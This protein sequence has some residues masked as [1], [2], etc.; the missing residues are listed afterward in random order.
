M[1]SVIRKLHA[2]QILDSRGNPTVEVEC[3]LSGGAHARAAVPSGAS[4]GSREAMEL[5]DGDPNSYRG[6]GVARAVA[7]VNGILASELEGMNASAQSE[8]DRRM[9]ELDGTENKS[10]LGAN[11]IL[12]VSLV[13]ARAAATASGV[14]LFRHLG[15]SDASRLPVPHMNILNGGVHAHWQG[16]DFQEFMIAPHGAPNF[17]EALRW[18]SEIYHA[19]LAILQDKGLSVGVGRSFGSWRGRDRGASRTSRRATRI[20][21]T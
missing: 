15:G 11:A 21:C 9:I 2:R 19:L 12:G 16:P 5:R 13:V 8:I 7:H 4:T 6:K 14:P 17:R 20:G 3:A 18:G 1:S 10:K